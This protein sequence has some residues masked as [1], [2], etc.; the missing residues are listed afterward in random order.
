MIINRA[1][2]IEEQSYKLYSSAIDRVEAPEAK[3]FLKELADWEIEHKAKLLSIKDN[4]DKLHDFT[5]NMPKIEDLQIVD[6]LKG[7]TLFES[8]QYEYQELLI[9]AGKREKETFE[10]YNELSK[11]FGDTE[12]GR[13]FKRLA[14]EELTHKNKIEKEYDQEI[15]KED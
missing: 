6:Y 3:T 9:F 4:P 13:F 8:T 2:N 15:L 5:E 1:L 11:K 14:A 10:Y 12:E 7:I